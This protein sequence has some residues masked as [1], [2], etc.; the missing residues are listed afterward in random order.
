MVEVAVNAPRL[1]GSCCVR[2][3]VCGNLPRMCWCL[4]GSETKCAS[5]CG[6]TVDGRLRA[7]ERAGGM[8][9]DWPGFLVC[10]GGAGG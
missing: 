6:G 4:R 5:A 9:D 1:G 2:A 3:R 8:V 7:P 10:P